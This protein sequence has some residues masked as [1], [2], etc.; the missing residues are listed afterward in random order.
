[1]ALIGGKGHSLELA[2]EVFKVRRAAMQ[3]DPNG[4]YEHRRGI[5]SG[6]RA[7]C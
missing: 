5:S 6:F 4:R 1:M 3:R 7:G 2:A